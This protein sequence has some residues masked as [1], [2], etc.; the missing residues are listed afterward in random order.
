MLIASANSGSD[1]GQSIVYFVSMSDSIQWGL[2]QL[3]QTD[4]AMSSAQRL[5]D[6]CD[7]E[8]EPE[9]VTEYDRKHILKPTML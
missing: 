8:E 5:L 1:T 7:L 3:I 6:M 9:L 2:R 4:V